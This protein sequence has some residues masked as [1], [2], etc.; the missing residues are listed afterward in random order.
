[1]PQRTQFVENMGG[2][3]KVNLYGSGSSDLMKVG[4]EERENRENIMNSRLL[5]AAWYATKV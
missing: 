4:R 3:K 5:R 2:G 1:M